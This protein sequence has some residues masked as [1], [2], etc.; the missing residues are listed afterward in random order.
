M[1]ALDHPFKDGVRGDVCILHVEPTQPAFDGIRVQHPGCDA[2]ADVS[3][4]LDAWYCPKCSR[5]GRVSGAWAIDMY[6]EAR[7]VGA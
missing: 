1:S 6:E 7:R 3:A 2:L 5:S 4:D